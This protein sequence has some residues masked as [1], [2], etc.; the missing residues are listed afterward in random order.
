MKDAASVQWDSMEACASARPSHS[1][2]LSGLSFHR[3][4]IRGSRR[5]V[6]GGERA[7]DSA[8]LLVEGPQAAVHLGIN[9]PVELVIDLMRLGIGLERPPQPRHLADGGPEIAVQAEAHGAVDG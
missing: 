7:A 5:D 3:L 4:A 6:R 2:A 9:A 8:D 1:Q